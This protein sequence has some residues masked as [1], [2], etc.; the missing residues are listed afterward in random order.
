MLL[1]FL[2]NIALIHP[3]Y[4]KIKNTY[5]NQQKEAK[6]I[7]NISNQEAHI[8]PETEIQSTIIK[9]NKIYLYSNL[10]GGKI[11][12]IEEKIFFLNI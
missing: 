12:F 11:I 10:E 3:V 7:K 9:N 1:A 6:H 8:L 5:I 2:L 4:L